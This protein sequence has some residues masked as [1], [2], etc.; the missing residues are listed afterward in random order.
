VTLGK[1]I[2]KTVQQWVR[3]P[4]D[5]VGSASLDVF[6]THLV[7]NTIDL[8]ELAIAPSRAQWLLEV[9]LRH[10][11]YMSMESLNAKAL[12]PGERRLETD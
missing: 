8:L 9:P 3:L 4:R 10:H 12:C 2:S 7:K 6:E 11:F 1:K 5:V